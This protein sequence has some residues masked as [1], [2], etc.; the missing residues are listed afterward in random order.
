MKYEKGEILIVSGPAQIKI[1]KG[2]CSIIGAEFREGDFT[3]HKGKSIPVEVM[4]ES[5]IEIQGEVKKIPHSTIPEKWKQIV[6]KFSSDLPKIILVLG[7]VDTG[8]TFFS[9]YLAN[10]FISRGFKVSMIDCDVGQSDIGPPGT[11]GLA[12]FEKPVVFVSELKPTSLFFLGSHSPG[13]HLV[14]AVVGVKELTEMAKE[15]SDV[16]IIDTPGWVQGDGGRLL[17]TSEIDILKPDKIILLQRESELEHLVKR[18]NPQ[19]IERVHVSKKATS[20][21]DA[22]RKLL[23]E[24]IASQYYQNLKKIELNFKDIA[25]D[26]V[27]FLTGQRIYPKSVSVLWAE[28]LSGWEGMLAVTEKPLTFEEQKL[29]KEEFKVFNVRNILT[30]KEKNLVVGLLDNEKNC[31]GLGI[32]E[33]IDWEKEKIILHTPITVSY[34]HLTLPT[35]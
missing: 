21:S 5:Q 11:I 12:V 16:V 3:V 1:K 9:T 23:R 6:E 14:P 24:K 33:K 15:M 22:D 8:K 13:L 29:L 35:N 20:T 32:I 19:K 4:E 27:F 17:R 2:L 10:S 30:G 7:E 26:R 34:T 18:E 28:R 25:T 31:L